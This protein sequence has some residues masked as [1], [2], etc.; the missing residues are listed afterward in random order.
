MKCHVNGDLRPVERAVSPIDRGLRY[1][2]AA[3]ERL[4]AANGVPFA[5]DAHRD[6]LANS[7]EALGI[8]V[9][10]DLHERVLATLAANDLSGALVRV[11][12]T[13]GEDTTAGLTPPPDPEPTVI[14]T[15]E[16]IGPIPR[17]GTDS[18]AVQTVTTKLIGEEAIPRRIQSHARLDRVLARRELVAD[19]DEALIVSDGGAVADC[20]GSAPLIVTRDS[21]RV[22]PLP[23]GYIPRVMRT[24]AL[25]C[26]REEQIPVATE[27]LTP[28][29]VRDAEEVL[30]A[31]SRW[32]I[33]PVASV[34]GIESTPGPVTE[35]LGQLVADR[36]DDACDGSNDHSDRLNAN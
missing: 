5:W 16:P 13:R 28:A 12:I 31:N 36:V 11:S 21:I 26:A 25:E 30:L 1:G 3:I 33:R 32:G 29:A 17:T 7:C 9:P 19:A 6:R 14:V 23:D 27:D 20:A 35:L 18:A 22:P 24:V 2:D 10:D 8:A 4:R 15:A 34:D